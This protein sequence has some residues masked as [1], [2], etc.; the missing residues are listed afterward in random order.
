MSIGAAARA[1]E[2]NAWAKTQS[3]PAF[4]DAQLQFESKV[5]AGLLAIWRGLGGGIPRRDQLT[6]QL[7]KPY[8]GDVAIFEQMANA[9]PR[10]RTRLIGT[11]ITQV[12]GE[13]QGK[14]VDEVVPPELL[15]RWH[16]LFDMTLQV[17]HP[18]RL[19]A[20][21]DFR[22]LDFLEAEMLF[23]PLLESGEVPTMIFSGVIFRRRP[24]SG[25]TQTA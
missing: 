24:P 19:T 14:M 25:Q 12:V 11:R 2:F 15:P 7:L 23:A 1:A 9:P 6:A 8:L 20:R 10:Y 21:V 4:C 18:F 5:L 16:Y 17:R 3:W 13:M 22:Q